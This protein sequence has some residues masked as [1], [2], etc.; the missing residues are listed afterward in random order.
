MRAGATLWLSFTA[1]PAAATPATQAG[2]GSETGENS[3]TEEKDD[4]ELATLAYEQHSRYPYARVVN[5]VARA[6]LA[7]GSSKGVF[8]PWQVEMQL[9]RVA[10]M[11]TSE[12]QVLRRTRDLLVEWEKAP[13]KSK[14]NGLSAGRW[15]VAESALFSSFL[16]LLVKLLLF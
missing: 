13:V 1:A 11:C 5:A 3:D 6:M 16:P 12:A 15:L 2:G 10:A 14:D 4:L 9:Q 7:T 8:L